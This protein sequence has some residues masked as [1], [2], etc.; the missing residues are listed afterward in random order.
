MVSRST[1][2]LLARSVHIKSIVRVDWLGFQA[3]SLLPKKARIR[4]SHLRYTAFHD[5]PGSTFLCRLTH[6]RACTAQCTHLTAVQHQ[7]A[8]CM[9]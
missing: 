4:M 2:N 7:A 8:F 1:E 5:P 6:S 9:R 3:H